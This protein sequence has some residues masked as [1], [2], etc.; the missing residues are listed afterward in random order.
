MNL[1]LLQN[2]LGLKFQDIELLE[3]AL[4]HSSYFNENPLTANGSNE[5]LEFLGDA[6]IG[7]I[8]AEELHNSHPGWDEGKLTEARSIIVRESALADV[9]QQICLG[10]HLLMGHGEDSAKGRTR[11]SNLSAALEA[12]TGALF[13]EFGYEIARQ[14][15]LELLA[16]HIMGVGDA[17]LGGLGD[18]RGQGRDGG[19]GRGVDRTARDGAEIFLGQFTRLRGRDV[20][21]QD[22]DGVV[23]TIVGAEPVAHR[24]HRRRVQVGHRTDGRVAIGVAFREQ[25]LQ[26]LVLVQAVGLVVALALLVL[27][28]AALQIERLLG[29]GAQHIAHA[30]AFH[31]QGLFQRRGRDRLEIVGAVEIGGPVHVGRAHVAHRREIAAGRVFRAA[32]HQVFEQVGEA[33]LSRALVLRSDVVPEVNGHDGRL[34]VFVHDDL[35]AVVEFEG[36]EGEVRYRRDGLFCSLRRGRDEKSKG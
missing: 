9:A 10:Q 17:V 29:D 11:P 26:L 5:R 34:M 24:L 13:I 25:G 4:T 30:V 3:L 28:D 27:N 31:E 36:F 20:A 12:L 15:V 8:V 21:G 18:R 19:L 35:E 1:E 32:E 7:Q 16:D 22:Q 23:G 33:G 6:V 14:V 2:K